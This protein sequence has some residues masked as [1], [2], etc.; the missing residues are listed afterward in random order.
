MQPMVIRKLFLAH[1]FITLAAAVVLVLWPPF[2]PDSVGMPLEKPQYL[3]C[4]FLAASE[5]ALSFL[6]YVG[7][8]T[9]DLPLVRLIATTLILFHL[10]TGALELTAFLQG[11]VGAAIFL[12]IVLRCVISLLFWFF[13]LRN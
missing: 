8:R 5:L 2:V 3:L 9:R 11:I 6:S 13:G 4:Y 12:N 1:A 10:A 7:S